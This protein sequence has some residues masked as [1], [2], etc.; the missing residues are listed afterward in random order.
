MEDL[1]P[2]MPDKGFP[3][4]NADALIRH[5]GTAPAA[6]QVLHNTLKIFHSACATHAYPSMSSTDRMAVLK[7]IKR[8]HLRLFSDFVTLAIQAYCLD[9]QVSGALGEHLR[10]PFPDGYV[11]VDGSF[12]LLEPVYERGPCYRPC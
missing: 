9:P 6:A 5:L 11:I 2:P 7:D 4:G 3:P 12:D 10:A 8:R 1:L